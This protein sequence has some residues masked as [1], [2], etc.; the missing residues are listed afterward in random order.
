MLDSVYVLWRNH[1][2]GDAGRQLELAIQAYFISAS[3][4]SIMLGKYL[5]VLPVG[6]GSMLLKMNN[7]KAY[8]MAKMPCDVITILL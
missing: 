2:R 1:T 3:C 8:T 4:C 6:I 7:C 5:C